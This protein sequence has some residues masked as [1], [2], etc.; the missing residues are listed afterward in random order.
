MPHG[1]C[2]FWRPEILWLSV[3]SDAIIAAAYYAIPVV[4]FLFARK[5][6]DLPFI[7][8]FF[9][10]SGFILLC[11]TTH[12]FEIVTV[13]TPM[14]RVLVLTKAAT[15]AISILTAVLLIPLIPKALSLRSPAELEAKNKELE[16]EIRERK[17][18]EILVREQQLQITQSAKMSALG[19]M[20]GGVAHEINNPLAG[21]KAVVSQMQE[22]LA[23]PTVDVAM[24]REMAGDVEHTTDRIAKIVHGMRSFS[25]D[26]SADAHTQVTVAD[27]IGETLDLCGERYRKHGIQ[28]EVSRFDHRL[29][30]TGNGTQVSQIL[31]NL[32][33]NAHDAVAELPE[34]WVKVE[35]RDTPEA[36]EFSV[37]DCGKGIPAPL[38]DKIFQPFFSTKEVGKGTGIGLSISLGLAQNHGGTLYLDPKSE[39]T[40]FV[41]RLPRRT[42]N[43]EVG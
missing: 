1:H 10:F 36:I 20:A 41:L 28:L 37:T 3:V 6:K 35:V 12:I 40:H 33:N 9:L 31:L 24:L 34:K 39:H 13:W 23:E 32:L 38:R 18:M 22:L 2:Y 43:A 14:Y 4:L 7:W 21:I 11:G 26:S 30:F 29:S 8:M 16:R 42:G 5:K 17:R 15:A 25:R 19:E 27:L